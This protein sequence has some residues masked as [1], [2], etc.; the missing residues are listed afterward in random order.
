[1]LP[2]IVEYL[3]WELLKLYTTFKLVRLNPLIHALRFR[4]QNL[5]NTSVNF[6]NHYINTVFRT[7]FPL[8]TQNCL[9]SSKQ[10]QVS[11]GELLPPL[12]VYILH[13]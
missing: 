1:M 13:T 9:T 3:G 7:T 4:Y 12:H 10:V 5:T 6:R 11:F 8:N 2:I